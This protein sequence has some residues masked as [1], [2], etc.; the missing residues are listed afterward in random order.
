MVSNRKFFD[1][2]IDSILAAT[3]YLD[4]MPD[5]VGFRFAFALESMA[6]RLLTQVFLQA[7]PIANSEGGFPAPFQ[8]HVLE[9]LKLIPIVTTVQGT[10][11]SVLVDFDALGDWKDLEKAYH[12]GARLE[13]GGGRDGYLWG[14]YVGQA[15]KSKS[16][17]NRYAV[18]NAVESGFGSFKFGSRSKVYNLPEWAS[19][20]ATM[21][22]RISIWGEKA[23]EWLYIQFGQQ[24][25]TPKI[26]PSAVFEDFQYLLNLEGGLLFESILAVEIETA[27]QFREQLGVKVAPTRRGGLQALTSSGAIRGGRFISRDISR[28]T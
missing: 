17:F 23:P 6:R 12:Q 15:L 14:P 11:V 20:E 2:D 10:Q 27:N 1:V 19:W 24:E 3:Q 22:Q 28:Y 26:P 9:A 5:R 18:W 21:Q 25:W 4:G 16:P 7:M 8:V 13:S